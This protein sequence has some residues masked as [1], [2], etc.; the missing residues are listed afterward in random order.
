MFVRTHSGRLHIQ[1]G[2]SAQ[3][4]P[5]SENAKPSSGASMRLGSVMETDA[6]MLR[7]NARLGSG[8]TIF[9]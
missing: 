4:P 2:F 9:V 8:S 6:K 1:M 3:G 5:S 7:A